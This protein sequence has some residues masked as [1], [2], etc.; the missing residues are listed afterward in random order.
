M[1][2]DFIHASL[3]SKKQ[4]ECMVM[5]NCQVWRCI[6]FEKG[7]ELTLFHELIRFCIFV[8]DNENKYGWDGTDSPKKKAPI[9]SFEPSSYFML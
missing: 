9:C 3:I 6:L 5:K 2:V 7:W 1:E 4:I 8:R